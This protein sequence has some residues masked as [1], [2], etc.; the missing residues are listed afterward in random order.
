MPARNSSTLSFVAL[1]ACVVLFQH[2]NWIPLLA[3]QSNG[4]RGD[5][6]RRSDRTAIELPSGSRVVFAR[7]HSAALEE[8]REYSIFLPPSYGKSKG[9][10]PVVYFLHG[11]WNDHTSWTVERYGR[12]Y[13]VVDRLITEKKIP[14]IIMVH[15]SGDNS[16]YT[17]YIGGHKNYE[18]YVVHDLI[19]HI[20]TTYSAKTGTQWRTIGGTSMGG[21]GALKIAFKHPELYSAAAAHSPIVLPNDPS[22][23]PEQT[24][25]SERFQF[26]TQLMTPIFGNPIDSTLW[27]ANN[28]LDLARTADL[29]GIR[30]YFDYG[31]AD[32]Y[33]QTIGLGEGVRAL[34][35]V[36]TDRGIPHVFKERPN[37]PHGWEFVAVHLPE[38]L[39]FLCESFK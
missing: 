18:E 21:F 24:R 30:I 26:F 28:P 11:M 14:E 4:G 10:F 12:L 23:L 39:S 7:F 36:L 1:V 29:R 6:R 20:E 17:N 3:Q 33:N 16:F 2:Q 22:H 13:E 15:P 27:K 34:H 9:K 37:E 38:S 19:R 31:T 32:R 25:N 35:Q 5:E 8:D